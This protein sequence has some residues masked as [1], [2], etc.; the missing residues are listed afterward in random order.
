MTSDQIIELFKLTAALLELHD[1]NVFKVKSYNSAVYNLDKVSEDF[2]SK[3]MAELENIDGIGKSLAQKIVSIITSGS[4]EDLDVLLAKTPLGVLKMMQIKG[5]GPKK[6]RLIWKELGIE[7]IN[8]LLL[9]CEKGQIATLKGFGEK[10]Q[11]III[12]SILFAEA[13][14]GKLLYA[15][16]EVIAQDLLLNLQNAGFSQVSMVGELRR[17]LEIIHTI[18]ILVAATP[19]VNLHAIL[20]AVPNIA[21]DEQQSGPF[22]WKGLETASQCKIEVRIC[23]ESDFVKELMIH[24]GALAHLQQEAVAGKN[25]LTFIKQNTASSEQEMFEKMGMQYLEPE[26]REGSFEVV[27]TLYEFITRVS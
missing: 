21:V 6:V 2:S 4:F 17:K 15:N 22:L 26:L 10:T 9:A 25:I 3:S 27:S 12:N 18:Q 19:G 8:G 5:I 1:E 16:A 20:N 13:Q 24:T 23:K 11:D 14:K 7:S